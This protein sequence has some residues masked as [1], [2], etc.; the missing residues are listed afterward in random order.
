M[1]SQRAKGRSNAQARAAWKLSHK[2]RAKKA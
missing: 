2:K 1:R